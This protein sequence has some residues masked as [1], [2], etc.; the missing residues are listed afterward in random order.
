MYSCAKAPCRKAEQP[1][2]AADIQKRLAVKPFYVEHL[3]E[4]LFRERDPLVAEP[5]QE[6]RP[7]FPETQT[8]PLC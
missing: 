5:P 7:V 3:P 6:P 1:A 8:A 4:R 2:A